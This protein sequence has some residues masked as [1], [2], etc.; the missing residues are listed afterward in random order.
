MRHPTRSFEFET[1][2]SFRFGGGTIRDL[3]QVLS[4][5]PARRWLLVSDRGVAG[6]GLV[7]PVVEQLQRAGLEVVLFDGVEADPPERIIHQALELGRGREVQGVVGFGGGSS[8]DVAKL[9]A[10]LLATPQ[11]LETIYGI[12]KARGPRLPLVQVPTTAGTGSEATPIAIVT[13]PSLEKKGVVSRCLL[14]DIAVLDPELTMGLPPQVTAATGVDA[15]VHAIEAYTSVRQKNP[16]SDLLACRALK[17]LYGAIEPAV[18]EG[19]TPWARSDMLHGAF[20]AG[21]AFANAPVAAVHALAYPLG[22]RYHLPHGLTNA[23]MLPAVLNFNAAVA[24]E[25]YAELA[26]LIFPE[27]ASAEPRER[28]QR[29][30]TEMSDLRKRLGMPNRLREVDVPREDLELLAREA[31][32]VERLLVNNPRPLSLPDALEL[33]EEA[34]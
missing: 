25:R 11:K 30:V 27:G 23:L 10:L 26:D 34:W 22:A 7:D 2:P 9:A 31:M 29:F 8:L 14:G 24:A 3:E 4:R 32:K 18:H 12:E 28:A 5:F 20:L 17:L 33:Y 19:A 21:M 6:A 1:L 13:T 15:M 16:H